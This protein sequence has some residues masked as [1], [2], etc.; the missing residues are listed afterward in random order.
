MTAAQ[1]VTEKIRVLIVDD[2]PALCAGL[3][4]VLEQS[5]MDVVGLA[6]WAEQAIAL[7]EQ[8][9]PDVILLDYCLKHGSTAQEVVEML[10]QRFRILVF[11][12]FGKPGTV[13]LLRRHGVCGYM[14]KDESMANL[15][16]G[17]QAVAAGRRDIFSPGLDDE[18]DQQ[19][20]GLLLTDR[21]RKI[22][23]L[24]AQ[25]MENKEI[26]SI[27]GCSPCTVRNHLANIMEKADT[28]NRAGL[29]S[30]FVRHYD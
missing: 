1:C 6:E 18:R 8:L 3:R 21:E 27:L 9:A 13:S 7:A 25:G 30:W 5:G 22:A 23:M 15:I 28:T 11:S 20:A 14:T 29:T 17:I 19:R 24:V 12:Q 2:H 4:H 16:R 26:A 10:G